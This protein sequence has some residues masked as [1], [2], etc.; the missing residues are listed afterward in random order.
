MFASTTSEPGSDP[1]S[2]PDLPPEAI[3]DA[4]GP[5]R[6]GGPRKPLLLIIDAPE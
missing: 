3:G 1:P 2:R 6:G 5:T 4:S